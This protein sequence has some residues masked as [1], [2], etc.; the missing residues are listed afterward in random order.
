MSDEMR[1]MHLTDE[2]LKQI[3]LIRYDIADYLKT[4]EDIAA[5]LNAVLEDGD[6]ARAARALLELLLCQHLQHGCLSCLVV[7]G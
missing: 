2:E 1:E 6:A 3:G 5:Y 4:D 7:V